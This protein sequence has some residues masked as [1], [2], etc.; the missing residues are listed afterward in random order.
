MVERERKKLLENTSW[1][2]DKVND[3]D[4]AVER[5]MLKFKSVDGAWRNYRRR[6]KWLKKKKIVGENVKSKNVD[7]KKQYASVLF[8]P[9]TEF[10]ALARWRAK[11]E[12]FEKVSNMK[13]KVIE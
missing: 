6:E 2:H 8:T 11:L 12:V 1:Y 13:I 3:T 10:S 4:E 5:Y 7:D 9:H